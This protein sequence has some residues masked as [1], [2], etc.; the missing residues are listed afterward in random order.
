MSRREKRT[1]DPPWSS[2]R[3]E[4]LFID[5][6]SL[7]GHM[8]PVDRCHIP[9]SIE[10]Y[11][12]KKKKK[13]QGRRRRISYCVLLIDRLVSRRTG[14]IEKRRPWKD[15]TDESLPFFSLSSSWCRGEAPFNQIIFFLSDFSHLSICS[16]GHCR[17][18]GSVTLRRHNESRRFQWNLSL[19]L[20][21]LSRLLYILCR[22]SS[23]HALSTR[24]IVSSREIFSKFRSRIDRTSGNDRPD[25]SVESE[26]P[27]IEIGC[28]S[29][30]AAAGPNRELS[31]SLP[32]NTTVTPSTTCLSR[33]DSLCFRMLYRDYFNE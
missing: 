15:K 16:H 2:I 25:Q 24:Q 13:F 32:S 18:H 29:A 28:G 1:Y 7:I 4:F 30:S 19:L 6:P 27:R 3:F 31:A 8:S 14:L 11:W 21:L 12:F 26:R 20:L 17:R 33:I 22:L 5:M 23:L 9:M 10:I